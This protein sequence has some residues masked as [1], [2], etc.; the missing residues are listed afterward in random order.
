MDPPADNRQG[1][2]CLCQGHD[3]A[4]NEYTHGQSCY[5]QERVPEK[6]AHI[7]GKF[8]NIQYV[9]QDSTQYDDGFVQHDMLPCPGFS[10]QAHEY[11]DNRQER[12][13]AGRDDAAGAQAKEC[14]KYFFK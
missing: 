7:N 10:H 6:R 13:Y 4:A 9:A 8:I 2:K 1:L 5:D 11:A 3:Q 14:Q 12:I